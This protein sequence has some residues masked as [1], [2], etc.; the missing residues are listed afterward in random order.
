MYMVTIT[1][2]KNLK[3]AKHIALLRKSTSV[4]YS[5]VTCCLLKIVMLIAHI[6]TLLGI[7]CGFDAYIIYILFV[8]FFLS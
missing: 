4:T 1:W 3:I 5:L 8:P 6:C 7:V 2:C